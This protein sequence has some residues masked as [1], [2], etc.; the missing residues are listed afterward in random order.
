M[1]V[2]NRVRFRHSIDSVFVSYVPQADMRMALANNPA[3][4]RYQAT[5]A[6]M[7]CMAKPHV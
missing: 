4:N 6:L 3:R 2:R 7:V 1:S 5:S